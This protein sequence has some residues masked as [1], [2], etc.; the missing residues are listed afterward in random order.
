MLFGCLGGF[1]FEVL[2]YIR[3]LQ[4][5]KLPDVYDIVASALLIILGGAVAAVYFGQVQSFFIA[6]QLGATSPAIIG[7][8]ASGSPPPPGGGGPGGGGPT[9]GGG[10]GGAI[11][12]DQVDVASKVFR[13]LRWN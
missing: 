1:L 4:N 3:K 11:S 9:S 8:W 13:A 12:I 7:A 6:V 2:K 5:R 10:G